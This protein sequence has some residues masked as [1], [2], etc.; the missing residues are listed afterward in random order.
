MLELETKDT[1]LKETVQTVNDHQDPV[2]AESREREDSKNEGRQREAPKNEGR[3]RED[4]KNED[5]QREDSKN[6]DIEREDSKNDD[7]EKDAALTS[8]S[9]KAVKKDQQQDEVVLGRKR[10]F[11]INDNEALQ[12]IQESHA[13]QDGVSKLTEKSLVRSL[14][15]HVDHANRTRESINHL[16]FLDVQSSTPL[17]TQ[18]EAS[19][20]TKHFLP[21]ISMDSALAEIKD[22]DDA[23]D[24]ITQ[25][26]AQ[27]HEL[28]NDV[29]GA[30]TNF[31]SAMPEEEEEMT[32]EEW[33]RHNAA[34][35]RKIVEDLGEQIVRNYEAEFDKVINYVAGLATID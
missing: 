20:A 15:L 33:I 28:H 9:L 30:L 35:C 22:L 11:E 2:Y 8:A 10:A 26:A 5:R 21:R 13:A 25:M 18:K 7:R 23:I 14:E 32:V 12:S 31:I 16:S 6:D 34:S 4:S 1:V 29:D 19:S 3:E 24:Y 17:K 27:G